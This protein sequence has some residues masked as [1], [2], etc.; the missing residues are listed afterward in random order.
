MLLKDCSIQ[1]LRQTVFVR[2]INILPSF[3]HR[4]PGGLREAAR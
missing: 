2:C 3:R 1:T 4:T